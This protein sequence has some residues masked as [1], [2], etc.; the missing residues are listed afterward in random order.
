MVLGRAE[1]RRQHHIIGPMFS[2]E[3]QLRSIRNVPNFAAELHPME[4]T[5]ALQVTLHYIRTML[6]G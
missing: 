5:S 1:R 4:D 3:S 2:S 6:L